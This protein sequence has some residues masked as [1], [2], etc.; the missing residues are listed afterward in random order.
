MTAIKYYREKKGFT[1]AQ[2]A[3]KMNTVQS[4]IAMWESGE[5]FPRTNK[6]QELARVLG[7][8]VDELFQ[9]TGQDQ[10]PA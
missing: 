2:L 6:L 1:Q 7:C 5:R 4:A 10:T 9:D 8:T 3:A